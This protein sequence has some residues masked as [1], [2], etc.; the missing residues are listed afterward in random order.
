MAK[1]FPPRLDSLIGRRRMLAAFGGLGAA[2]AL[3]GCASTL[4]TG[5]TDTAKAAPA[6]PDGVDGLIGNFALNLEYMEAE[7]YTRGVT[8]QSITEQG[9][10]V[11]EKAGAVNGGQKVGFSKPI[12]ADYAAELALNERAHVKYYRDVLG[13]SAV[14]RPAIDF[15]GG[16][17]GAAQAA[18]LIPSGQ[19]MDPFANET[20]FFLCG[21]L[22]ED[23]GITAYHG[24]APL[25]SDKTFLAAAAGILAVEAY[26]MGLVRGLLFEAG[27]EARRSANAISDARDILDGPE[28]DLDQGIEVNGKPNI[29]PCDSN[30]IAFAR[31]PRQVANIVFGKVDA[32]KG[33]FYPN[34]MSGELKVLLAL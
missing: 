21:M 17:T 24:A 28:E 3:G 8:G 1:H 20:N 16:F 29:V 23:V 7:F 9:I 18:G 5:R 30:G 6:T 22:F 19:T 10:K 4:K 31:K 33:G 34:G 12:F 32:T 26:H 13:K 27:A 14:D 25:I 11:G 2:C 15:I